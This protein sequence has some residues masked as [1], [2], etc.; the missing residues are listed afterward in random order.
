[1]NYLTWNEFSP[2]EQVDPQEQAQV[3]VAPKSYDPKSWT[4]YENTPEWT[5]T[6]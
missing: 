4:Y 2:Q 5:Y 3:Q 1:M 6:V